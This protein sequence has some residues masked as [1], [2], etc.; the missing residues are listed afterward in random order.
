MSEKQFR[1]GTFSHKVSNATASNNKRGF[2]SRV[3]T[4]E[5]LVAGLSGAIFVLTRR[6]MLNYWNQVLRKQLNL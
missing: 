2:W 4:P 1:F 3:F 5:P 6:G